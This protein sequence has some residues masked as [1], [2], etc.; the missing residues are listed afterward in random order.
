MILITFIYV[1]SLSIFVFGLG[2]F[3]GKKHVR[4]L[5]RKGG[6]SRYPYWVQKAVEEY[7]ENTEVNYDGS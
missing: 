6:E 3:V 2:L 5:A 7:R 1:M 4:I